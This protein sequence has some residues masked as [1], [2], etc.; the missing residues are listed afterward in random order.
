MI[1]PDKTTVEREIKLSVR[2]RFAL[3]K[4]PGTQLPLRILTATYYDTDN[5]RLARAGITLRHR[6]EGRKGLWH[7]KLPRDSSRLEIEF[8]GD[9]SQ[10]PPP[11][12]ALLFAHLRRQ[13]LGPIAT[14]RTRRRGIRVGGTARPTADVV[15]DSVAALKGRQVL[16]RLHEVEVELLHGTEKALRRIEQTLREAGAEDGDPRPKLLQVLKL[17]LPEAADPPAPSAPP[18]EHLKVLL[19]E[20]LNRILV[21][22]PGTRLGREPEELHQLRVATRRLRAYLR[23]AKAHL[24]PA[25]VEQIRAEVAWLGRALGPVRDLDVLL[26]YL[27]QEAGTLRVT[28][29]RAFAGLLE[30]LHQQ[31]TAAHAT[32]VQTLESDRY[33]A[34]LEQLEAAIPAP[35]TDQGGGSLAEIA[36]REFK[37]LRRTIK[38]HG[39]DA[40]DAV[41][42]QIRIKVKRARYAAELARPSVG[43]P[44]VRF[45]R[46]S[47]AFQELLGE[48]NDA[49]VTEQRLRMLLRHAQGGL[50]AVSL[51]RLLE[52]QSE[53]RRKA[54]AALPEAWG[55]LEKRG[56]KAWA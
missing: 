7:V 27:E 44:A 41:L 32:L 9:H 29:R 3:P 33:L 38:E 51:G 42:H 14:L 31:R 17:E 48:H 20:Q 2:P 15:L 11:I 35:P 1:V 55:R 12:L 53:R 26:E 36:G 54:R 10:P 47:K 45:L 22:D 50:V 49:V 21:H 39:L 24:V 19:R 56:K 46:E 40:T 8:R 52:R 25:W 43:K 13:P 34:L 18:I 6:V 23:A 37:K 4:L 30:R 28:E 16:G 5:Y